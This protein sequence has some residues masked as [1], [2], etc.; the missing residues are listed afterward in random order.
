M[1]RISESSD[2]ADNGTSQVCSIHV[3]RSAVKG[4]ACDG[5]R[6]SGGSN[7]WISVYLLYAG[8]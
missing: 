5:R 3:N 8:A 1:T 6:S 4:V 2:E 7:K